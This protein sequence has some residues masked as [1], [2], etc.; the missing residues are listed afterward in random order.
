MSTSL[1]AILKINF[2]N[3]NFVLLIFFISGRKW[4]MFASSQ[5]FISKKSLFV[6]L[7]VISLMVQFFSRAV[8]V[9]SCYYV[10]AIFLTK[11]RTL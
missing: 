11:R 3:R 9:I 2:G 8:V 6:N 5:S 7:A 1:H 4:R 10:P